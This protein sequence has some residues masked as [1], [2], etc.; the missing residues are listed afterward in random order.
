MPQNVKFDLQTMLSA[1]PANPQYAKAAELNA[2]IITCARTAQENLYKMAIGFKKMRDEKLYTALG[3]NSFG[4]YCEKETDMKRSSVYNYITVV[5]K[6]PA[7]F[8]QRL[9]K[10]ETRKLLLLAKIPEEQQEQI[11]ETVDL[12]N[13]TVNELKEQIKELQAEKDD[14]TAECRLAHTQN[15]VDKEKLENELDV[16][17]KSQKALERDL[18]E[19][20]KEKAKLEQ[21]IKELE[22]RPIEVAVQD[23]SEETEKLL[24][25]Q[26]IKHS[27][28]LAVRESELSDLKEK[29]SALQDKLDNAEVPEQK[30]PDENYLL[31]LAAFKNAKHAL[32]DLTI[33]CIKY[34]E[35]DSASSAR[36]LA[37]KFINDIENITK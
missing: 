29:L 27:K 23:N 35:A 34:S 16:Y 37:Q 25:E 11:I 26:K 8:V 1:P 7:E 12:E 32:H 33:A 17:R 22:N 20:S 10:F 3:Y 31:W 36:E 15:R 21:Q 9:D 13:T 28:E 6:L 4:E 18:S 30:E 19:A 14:L 24:N 5:E 2:E